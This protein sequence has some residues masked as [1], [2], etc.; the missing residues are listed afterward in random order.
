MVQKVYKCTHN[1]K[2]LEFLHS[3]GISGDEVSKLLANNLI[4]GDDGYPVGHKQDK[5]HY[6][7]VTFH[8]GGSISKN[9]QD[10]KTVQAKCNTAKQP[11]FNKWQIAFWVLCGLFFIHGMLVIVL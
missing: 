1:E 3:R 11:K 7:G 6:K 2:A 4:I 10:I 9:K 8:R 5:I